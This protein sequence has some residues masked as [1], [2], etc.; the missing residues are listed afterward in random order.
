MIE[1]E[2]L[3]Q[4]HY[5]ARFAVPPAGARPPWPRSACTA[6]RP[7]RR[8]GPPAWTGSAGAGGP[9]RLRRSGENPFHRGSG[10]WQAAD[11]WRRTRSCPNRPT[12]STRQE[13]EAPDEPAPR[14]DHLA[15]VQP[16]R[17]RDGPQPSRG[18]SRSGPRRRRC[19]RR[20]SPPVAMPTSRTAASDTT[21]A[22]DERV[23]TS[24]TADP[25]RSRD[26]AAT[27]PVAMTEGTATTDTMGMRPGA[28][29]G[30]PSWGS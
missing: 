1:D 29:E 16:A 9:D 11:Q 13:A 15:E 28:P 10:D 22:V 18:W 23:A 30:S 20:P 12:R 6:G 4:G 25:G 27:A 26:S 19:L 8:R 24:R 2:P 7:A 17:P 14:V 21:I 3:S 5:R